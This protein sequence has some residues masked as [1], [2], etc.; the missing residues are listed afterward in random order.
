MS[1]RQMQ[2]LVNEYVKRIENSKEQGSKYLTS[3]FMLP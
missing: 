1:F 3:L 2:N